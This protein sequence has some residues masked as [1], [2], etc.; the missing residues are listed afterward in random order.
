MKQVQ[1]YRYDKTPGKTY[2]E[3]V[4]DGIAHFHQ[5]GVDNEADDCGYGNYSTAIVE[6]EDGTIETPPAYMVKFIH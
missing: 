2:M 4:E 6:R 3:K 5:W 1:V